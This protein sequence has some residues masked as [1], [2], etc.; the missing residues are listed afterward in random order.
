MAAKN[1]NDA[2]IFEPTNFDFEWNISNPTTH[3][4]EIWIFNISKLY[5]VHFGYF[6]FQN[7]IFSFC[8]QETLSNGNEIEK[9]KTC[10]LV[11]F[12]AFSYGSGFFL[13]H[14]NYNGIIIQQLQ[15]KTYFQ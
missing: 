1:I 7:G 4:N 14:M 15:K 6:W 10:P 11:K 13:K 8:L 2:I 5:N 9:N 12:L 3:M